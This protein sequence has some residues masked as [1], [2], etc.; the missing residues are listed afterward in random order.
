MI[1]YMRNHLLI[2][3]VRMRPEHRRP[4]TKDAE[5]RVVDR[6]L[7]RTIT[8]LGWG[9]FFPEYAAKRNSVK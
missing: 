6:L 5:D 3:V 1:S 4:A 2:Y 8:M 7:A 9:E